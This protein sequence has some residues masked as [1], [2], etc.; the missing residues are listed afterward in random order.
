MITAV[1][2]GSVLRPRG[3]GGEWMAPKSR[4]QDL[5]LPEPS[6][7]PPSPLGASALLAPISPF[8]GSSAPARCLRLPDWQGIHPSDRSESW[9]WSLDWPLANREAPPACGVTWSWSHLLGPR[10]PQSYSEGEELDTPRWPG[11]DPLRV[12]P[13]ITG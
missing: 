8:Q 11:R 12:T 2:I 6:R 13:S 7:Q 1:I 5:S 4:P 10:F 3:L 9:G